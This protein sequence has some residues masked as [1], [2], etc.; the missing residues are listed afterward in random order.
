MLR[1]RF[2]LCCKKAPISNYHFRFSFVLRLFRIQRTSL[3]NNGAAR[4]QHPA[5]HLP[6]RQNRI[7][8]LGDAKIC[9]RRFNVS[10]MRIALSYCKDLA[11]SQTGFK[12]VGI[13]NYIIGFVK[14][15]K[16]LN[17]LLSQVINLHHLARHVCV[18]TDRK[19][20]F[21]ML[22]QLSKLTSS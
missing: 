6:Q 22:P 15:L 1:C 21:V 19:T 10:T 17:L 18:P 4:V 7:V 8:S 3:S 5:N 13:C 9:Q 20:F 16:G 12:R 14:I 11:S 2:I